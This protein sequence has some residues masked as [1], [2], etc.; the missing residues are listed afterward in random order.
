MIIITIMQ[1]HGA[2]QIC[3]LQNLERFANRNYRK[4]LKFVF[5]SA[6]K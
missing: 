3:T 6:R 2:D 5:L 4:L 1:K